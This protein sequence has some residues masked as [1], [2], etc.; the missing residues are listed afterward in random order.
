[1]TCTHKYDKELSS[2]RITFLH[3]QFAGIELV[4]PRIHYPTP[5]PF[6]ASYPRAT[7]DGQR[8]NRVSNRSSHHAL[9][10]LAV[11][12]RVEASAFIAVKE[13]RNGVGSSKVLVP[14]TTSPAPGFG[15]KIK[16]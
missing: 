3:A 4:S 12:I 10:N 2:S 9:T 15:A 7:A 5:C 8:D 14:V 16:F 13:S 11:C 1:M 6:P